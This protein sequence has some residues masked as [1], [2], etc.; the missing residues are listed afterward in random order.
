MNERGTTRKRPYSGPLIS[1]RWGLVTKS[2]MPKI[3]AQIVRWMSHPVYFDCS[4][5]IMQR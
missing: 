5:V 1:G 3:T 2:G 4:A